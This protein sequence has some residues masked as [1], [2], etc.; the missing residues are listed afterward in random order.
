[1]IKA[2][3]IKDETSLVKT[4]VDG[5]PERVLHEFQNLAESI[6]C[7]LID[8]KGLSV[9]EATL[10]LHNAVSMAYSDLV[11]STAFCRDEKVF[12]EMLDKATPYEN[13]NKGADEIPSDDEVAPT[14]GLSVKVV[15]ISSFEDFDNMMKSIKKGDI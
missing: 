4:K 2:K 1:M 7:Y 11:T 9:G 12:G 5:Q 13:C 8:E 15:K 3:A 14:D 10:C 6:I